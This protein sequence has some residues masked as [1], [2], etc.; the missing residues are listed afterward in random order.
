MLMTLPA[1]SAQ[2]HAGDCSSRRNPRPRRKNLTNLAQPILH[3]L[4]AMLKRIA[5][6]AVLTAQECTT[7]AAGYAVE[8][9][10]CAGRKKCRARISHTA[11]TAIADRWIHSD[12]CGAAVGK[13]RNHGC[14][15]LRH[16]CPG[17]RLGAAVEVAT[18][19]YWRTRLRLPCPCHATGGR[20]KYSSLGERRACNTGATRLEPRSATWTLRRT[21]LMH[22]ATGP[23]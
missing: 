4:P 18:L 6:V 5:G 3:P 7:H 2:R 13:V 20:G 14:P 11:Q 10:G 12:E 15:G 22:G 9:A 17:L 23:D 1:R 19:G 21:Q 8:H 16:G